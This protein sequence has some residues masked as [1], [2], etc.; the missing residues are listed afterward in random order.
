MAAKFLKKPKVMMLKLEKESLIVAKIWK[1]P[2]VCL[3]DD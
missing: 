1:K 2:K 3:L